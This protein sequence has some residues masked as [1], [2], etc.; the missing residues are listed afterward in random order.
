MWIYEFKHPT[1]ETDW[2]FAPNMKEAKDFYL[3]FTECGDLD[4]VSVKRVPKSKWSEMVILDINETEPDEDE[5]Y[6]QDEYS[7]G[8]KIQET[9]AE[10]AARN[11]HTEL[12]AT[13]EY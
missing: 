13:T 12:I 7:N 4:D 1:G 6:N 10:Y 11:R 5:D 8:F 9:F 2:V 3:D